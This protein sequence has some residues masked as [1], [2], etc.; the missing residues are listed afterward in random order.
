MLLR[1]RIGAECAIASG[2]DS[3]DVAVVM[4]FTFHGNDNSIDAVE[5][6]G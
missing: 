2:A 3:A 4:A 5:Q 1:E 6:I